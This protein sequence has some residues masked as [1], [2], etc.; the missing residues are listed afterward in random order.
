MEREWDAAGIEFVGRRPDLDAGQ[1][2]LAAAL[3]GRGVLLLLSGEAGIGK[4]RLA[5]ELAERAEAEGAVVLWATC[6]EGPGAPSLWPWTQILRAYARRDPAALVADAGPGAA[7]LARLLP[8]GIP[9]APGAASPD[10][11]GPPDQ[12][13]F[14]LFDSVAAF[15]T[16]AA[17]RRPLLIVIDDLQSADIPSLLLLRMVAGELRPAP[18]AVLAGYRYPDL[19]PE[20]A[21]VRLLPD[22]R[23]VATASLTLYGL[24]PHEIS[25]LIGTVAGDKPDPGLVPAV[26]QRTAGNPLFVREIAR[27]LLTQGH[28]H[29]DPRAA[30]GRALPATVQGVISH[31]LS[32]LSKACMEVLAQASV[33]GPRFSLDILRRVTG[34]KHER[35]LDLCHEAERAGNLAPVPGSATSLAFT[36]A[37]IRDVLYEGLPP[38]RRRILHQ[39]IGE[40][41]EQHHREDLPHHLSE[42]AHHFLLA[43][44]GGNM[45]KALHYARRA[46][47]QALT[48]LAYEEAAEHFAHVLELMASLGAGEGQRCETLLAL[49]DARMRAGDW[50]G[51]AEAYEEAAASARHRGDAAGLARAALGLGAGLG[52]FEVRLFDTRQIDLLREALDALRPEDSMLQAWVLARLSVALSLLADERERLALTERAVE[53]ARRVGDPAV[54]AYAL[55][56]HCDALAGPD[57]VERRLAE[58]REIV[59]LAAQAGNGDMELLG[60]RLL[61]VALLEL[62]DV[63]GADAEIEAFT[64][65]AVRL[66]QPLHLWFVPLWRAMRALMQGHLAE[67]EQQARNASEIGRRGHSRNSEILV[68]AQSITTLVEAGRAA[69]ACAVL[70]EHFPTGEFPSARGWAAGVLALAGRR[71]EA[72]ALLDRLAGHRFAEIPRD[73]EWVPACAWR[74]RRVSASGARRRQRRSTS[75]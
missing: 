12:L 13:R 15:L 30:V 6:W 1:A 19:H 46:G 21:L 20:S 55:S 2:A 36:H 64:R 32:Y 53:V 75:C 70:E 45:R 3:L 51:A 73:S 56:A 9:A 48:V 7:D 41:I 24:P 34:L 10:D 44:D 62:G 43:G 59:P 57:H 40:A 31:R 33:A 37:L 42:L 25:R 68:Q 4:T 28:G 47:R 58:A 22:L 5:G 54:L 39:R 8:E 27:L 11:A 69:E 65:T 35:L 63:V 71:A 60:R 72:G 23:R 18:V 61:L 26:A 38:V 14:R 16:N 29:L 66:R 67:V 49:G 74:R 50:P 52:G 17:H